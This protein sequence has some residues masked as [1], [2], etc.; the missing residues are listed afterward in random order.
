MILDVYAEFLCNVQSV[1]IFCFDL[2]IIS[3]IATI[4]DGE[5]LQA[6]LNTVVNLA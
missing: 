1:S 6:N 2:L 3:P 5:C 4:S